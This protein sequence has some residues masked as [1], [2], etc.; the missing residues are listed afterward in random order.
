GYASLFRTFSVSLTGVVFS[1]RP[2]E[3]AEDVLSAIRL[4]H[5]LTVVDAL[6]GPARL[7]FVATSGLN[8]ATGGDGLP[9]AGPVRVQARIPGPP[10]ARI[11]L[12][13]NGVRVADVEGTALDREF[14]E[15]VAVYRV[16]VGLPA[17][18]GTPPVPWI[19]SNPIFAGRAAG[20]GRPVPA[21]AGDH[22]SVG[23]VMGT[24]RPEDWTVEHSATSAAAVDVVTGGLAR[25]ETHFRY[26]LSGP[27]SAGPFAAAAL[28]VD[29]LAGAGAVQL[30]LRSDRPMRVSAELRVTGP[31]GDERWRRSA[32]VDGTPRTVTLQPGSVR[33]LTA[34]ET[35]EPAMADVRSVLVVVDTLN[36]PS[37]TAGRIWI[38]SVEVLAPAGNP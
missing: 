36:T 35:L 16:E 33:P 15:Q 12:I 24:P 5:T 37:G 38:E 2:A 9:L 4:G 3:D 25:K 34:G 6:A 31:N 11:T 7:D 23:R 17:A 13:R 29:G 14:A 10:D 18:P 1:G 21:P 32:Y 20:W 30:R 8:V 26:A 22:P 19:L 28:P 27:E